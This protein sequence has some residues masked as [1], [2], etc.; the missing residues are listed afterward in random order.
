MSKEHR[1]DILSFRGRWAAPS[2]YREVLALA[3]PLIL[4]TGTM[5]LQQFINRMFLSWYSP[6]ALAASL[7]SGTLAFTMLCF[8]IGT[9]SYANTFVAQYHGAG[10]PQR[11]AAA[12]WQAVYLALFATAVTIPLALTGRWVFALAGHAPG[13]VTQEV[14]YFQILVCGGGF[15]ILSSA[16]S[17]FFTGRGLT[18]TVMTVN[19]VTALLNVV[20][21]YVLIFGHG[22]LPE[23]GIAGAAYGSVLSSAVGAVLFVALFLGGPDRR[24]YGVWAARGFDRELF[25]R[26]LRFGAPSG[27]HFMLDLLGWSLFVIFVGR[28]GVRELGATNLAF[29]INSLVFMP[30]IGMA[31]ATAT[32]VGQRLGEG[33]DD[34]AARVTWSSFHLTFIYMAGFAALYL[35]MPRVF[36]APF[37]AHADPAEFAALADMATVMLAFVA[38]Y[39][40]FDGVNLIFSAALKGAGDTVFIMVTSAGLG[41]GL[42]VLPTWLVCRTGHGNIW[43]AWGFLSLFIIALA[44]CYL[45]RF[46][47][48]KWRTMRVTETFHAPVTAVTPPPEVPLTD[49]FG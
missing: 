37:G 24:T 21:D 31:I 6:E 44:G 34:L 38:L 15:G 33:R 7:P 3:G 26:L 35:L 2:G 49:E 22:G 20:L 48:G 16:V 36:L 17:A 45:A 40:L 29:Q 32:L 41:L 18:R 30:M 28:L 47:R 10:Q 27:L 42:M 43:L 8:F 1:R 4:S 12:V 19:I 14:I 23:L 46:L 5:T 25:G 9:A 11:I 13:V 39:S